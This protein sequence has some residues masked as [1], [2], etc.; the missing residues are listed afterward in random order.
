MAEFTQIHSKCLM[1]DISFL[2]IQLRTMNPVSKY[3][4][5]L[6]SSHTTRP[7]HLPPKMSFCNSF[8]LTWCI[9]Y[10]CY[11]EF[12]WSPLQA[13]LA[14]SK[15]EAEKVRYLQ[16]VYFLN[17]EVNN[18]WKIVSIFKE[19]LVYWKD[20]YLPNRAPCQTIYTWRDTSS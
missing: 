5:I 16:S 15:E 4:Y 1:L 20:S 14:D 8:S 12:L 17:T 6:V 7:F 10:T 3:H 11:M 2:K 19:D 13:L 9:C 18:E